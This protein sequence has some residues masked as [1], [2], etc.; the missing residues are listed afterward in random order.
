[1]TDTANPPIHDQAEALLARLGN[2]EG[3]EDF[4]ANS[5]VHRLLA[6]DR[7]IAA[8]WCIKDVQGIRPDLTDD[9]AWEVLEE[10][11]DKHDAELGIS[12]LT[13][14]V[15]AEELFGDASE[16]DATEEEQP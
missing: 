9:Q 15:F 5:F 1:M 10:V 14:E 16:T 6:H 8:I 12:W 3:E 13:L 4:D 2:G 7:K 11:G